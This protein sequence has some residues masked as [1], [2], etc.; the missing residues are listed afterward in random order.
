MIRFTTLNHF[1]EHYFTVYSLSVLWEK[2]I[3]RFV[4][5]VIKNQR[6]VVY[7]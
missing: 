1:F 2:Q 3:G 6:L 5:W 4:L 7:G